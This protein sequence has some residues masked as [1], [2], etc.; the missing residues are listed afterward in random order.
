M[1]THEPGADIDGAA[2]VILAPRRSLPAISWMTRHP[3]VE[4]SRSDP[5]RL[6]STEY[7][8]PLGKNV[9]RSAP[10][11][12]SRD[13]GISSTMEIWNS[14]PDSRSPTVMRTHPKCLTRVGR[15]PVG[16]LALGSYLVCVL[17][18]EEPQRHAFDSV[19]TELADMQQLTQRCASLHGITG[20]ED[21]A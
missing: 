11:S 8:R 18:V 20:L 17:G 12:A 14:R 3:L 1:R 19:G 10:S 5:L 16:E 6:P 9:L 13:S 15:S 21:G 4:T 2:T 7:L